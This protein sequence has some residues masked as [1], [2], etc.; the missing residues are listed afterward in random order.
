MY[1]TARRTLNPGQQFELEELTQLGAARAIARAEGGIE[2]LF[3]VLGANNVLGTCT[4]LTLT[5]SQSADIRKLAHQRGCTIWD[6]DHFARLMDRLYAE[7]KGLQAEGL[8]QNVFVGTVP[9]VTVAPLTRGVSPEAV[10]TGRPKQDKDGYYEY[11]THFWVWDDAFYEAP[12]AYPHFSR[13][14]ARLIDGTIDDYNALIRARAAKEGW[15]VIDSC[16]VL[17]SLAFR[18]SGGKPRYQFPSAL[19]RALKNNPQTSFRVFPPGPSGEQQLL[20]DT[21]YLNIR[22]DPQGTVDPSDFRQMQERYTGGL[23]SLDGVHPTTLGYGIFAHEA[24]TVMEAVGVA[25]ATPDQLDWD[26]IV[27]NDALVKNPPQLLHNL[28]DL[29]GFLTSRAPLPQLI[30]RLAGYGAQPMDE[31]PP[32]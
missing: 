1:R 3:V 7:V 30:Q 32:L 19:V 11:Y 24:L 17:D 12:H 28:R 13:E 22:P 16:A 31:R 26:A 18:R 23:F 10:K 6:P 27:D 2:N 20:L 25:G 9:H 15:H 4:S 5:W 29:L 21:R 8:V 14:D